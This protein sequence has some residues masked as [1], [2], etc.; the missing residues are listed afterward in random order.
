MI[1]NVW[2]SLSWLMLSK[3]PWMSNCKEPQQP[4]FAWAVA[5]SCVIARPA[6]IAEECGR[7][8]NWLVGTRLKAP[9]SCSIPCYNLFPV[10]YLGI[11]GKRLVCSSPGGSSQSCLDWVR[12]LSWLSSRRS[13]G[14]P[15]LGIERQTILGMLPMPIHHGHF[16]RGRRCCWCLLAL[17]QFR[18]L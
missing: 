12:P 6:W 13:G 2:T 15:R 1:R 18:P 4:P 17:R 9:M 7:A 8:P 5:M 10:A 14:S 11:R 16:P 3:N